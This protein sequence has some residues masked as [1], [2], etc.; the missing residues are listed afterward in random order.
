MDRYYGYATRYKRSLR[1]RK[2]YGSQRSWGQKGRRSIAKAG[3]LASR[4]GRRRYNNRAA[5]NRQTGG[6]LGIEKKFFDVTSSTAAIGAPTGATSGVIPA[7]GGCTGCMTAPAQGDSSSN[8]DGN[9]IVICEINCLYAITVAAQADQTATDTSCIVFVALV[10]D[11]QTNGAT[12]TSENVFTNPSAAAVLAADPFR[13]MSFTSRYK[14]LKM[15][16]F[17]LRI[18]TLTYDGTNIEQTGFH[19]TGKLKWRGSMP[20]TFTTAS[21]TADVA[22]VT[23]NSVNLIAFCSNTSLAPILNYNC[24]TRFYG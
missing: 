2:P 14:I 20:V 17:N 6:L 11:M 7:T 1:N 19:T 16:R 5:L 15:K 12:M 4:F 23:D 21:T 24:R 10:Q 18:P 3:T 22:N 8:R 13:N 9:K